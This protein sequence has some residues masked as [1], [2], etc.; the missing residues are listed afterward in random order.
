[1]SDL[2]DSKR[3]NEEVQRFLNFLAAVL[4]GAVTIKPVKLCDQPTTFHVVPQCVS[5]DT[6]KNYKDNVAELT[7]YAKRCGLFK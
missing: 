1:M 5:R 7:E 2:N 4:G 6:E 3:H